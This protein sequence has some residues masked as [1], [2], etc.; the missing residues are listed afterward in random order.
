MIISVFDTHRFDRAALEKENARLGH[1]LRFFDV[2]LD[3]QD[4]ASWRRVAKRSA[5]SS[6][7]C[8]TAPTLTALRDTRRP[9]DRAA[10]GRL[11]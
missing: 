9:P 2:R 11:Q 5:L 1:E 8:S 3:Q 7:M 4:G 10:L 6:T